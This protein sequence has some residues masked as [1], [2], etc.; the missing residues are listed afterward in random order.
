MYNVCANIHYRRRQEQKSRK[1][2]AA[3]VHPLQGDLLRS[4]GPHVPRPE[5]PLTQHL[6]SRGEQGGKL[7]KEKVL[8]KR[9]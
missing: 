3:E 6:H 5:R 8:H 9:G 7:H 1:D 2:S 4:L